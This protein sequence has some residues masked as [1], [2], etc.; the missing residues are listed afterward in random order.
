MEDKHLTFQLNRNGMFLSFGFIRMKIL[1][2]TR[3][4]QYVMNIDSRLKIIRNKF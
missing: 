1:I 4:D 2:S 3:W